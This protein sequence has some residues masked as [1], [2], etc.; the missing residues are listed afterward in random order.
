MA[1]PPGP[2]EGAAVD[3]PA[4]VLYGQF[5]HRFSELTE[6]VQRVETQHRLLLERVDQLEAELAQAR[7]QL[8][9]LQA[10]A[11][12]AEPRPWWLRWWRW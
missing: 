7:A 6:T 2:A 8:A 5:L 1:E 3:D 10:P 12:V 11:S 4:L 9:Q